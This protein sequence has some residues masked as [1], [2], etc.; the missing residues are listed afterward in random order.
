MEEPPGDVTVLLRKVRQGQTD[1]AEEMVRVAR[2]IL[3]Q[4]IELSKRQFISG[5]EIAHLHAALGES[6]L[7]LAQLERAY[8][9]QQPQLAR[10]KVDPMLDPLRSDP[11]FT[12]LVRKMNLED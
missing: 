12:A 4:L 3:H 6:D 7:A 10:L 1:A 9:E 11:R 5:Y 8:R 2:E